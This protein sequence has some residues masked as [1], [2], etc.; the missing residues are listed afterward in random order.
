MKAAIPRTNGHFPE[1]QREEGWALLDQAARHY[2][3]MS[4]EDFIQ[5]WERGDFDEDPERPEVIRVAMMVP[6]AQ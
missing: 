5:A 1:L 2:L 3:D 4:A 6:L